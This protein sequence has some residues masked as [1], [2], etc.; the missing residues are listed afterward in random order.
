LF[1]RKSKS[2]DKGFIKSS[3]PERQPGTAAVEDLSSLS[4]EKQVPGQR[5][6]GDVG[7]FVKNEGY[8][9]KMGWP[10]DIVTNDFFT[11]NPSRQEPVS[12]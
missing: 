1:P 6:P 8:I 4:T 7:K 9:L 5:F 10:G 2:P 11:N 12:P 3:V